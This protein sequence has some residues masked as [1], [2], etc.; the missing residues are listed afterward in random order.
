MCAYQHLC[1]C[2]YIYE[3]VGHLCERDSCS[4]LVGPG[5]DIAVDIA[6]GLSL[7]P[8]DPF[9]GSHSGTVAG[10]SHGLGKVPD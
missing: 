3:I 9:E 10:E 8:N 6:V 2:A 1:I 5:F 7:H 4:Y